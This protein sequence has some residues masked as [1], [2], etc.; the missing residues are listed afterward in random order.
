MINNSLERELRDRFEVINI[1][2]DFK[3]ARINVDEKY[4]IEN[5]LLKEFI[6]N[7]IETE[8]FGYIMKA[9]DKCIASVASKEEGKKT[10]KL[11][12]KHYMQENNLIKLQQSFIE[13]KITYI[14][15]KNN[16]KY[17]GTIKDNLERI[18][19]YNNEC[20]EPLI[21][22]KIIGISK[23]KKTISPKVYRTYSDKINI[24]EK[25]IISEGEEGY[26]LVNEQIVLSNNKIKHKEVLGEEVIKEPSKKIIV[27]G[28]K[29]PIIAG[30][31]FLQRPSIGRISSPYGMRNGKLH[32]GI[33][34]AA[35]MGTPIKA[36][37]D[38][39]VIYAGWQMGYGKVINIDH[40]NGITTVYAHCSLIKIKKGQKV[41]RGE[42]IGNVGSTGKS[43]GPHLHFEVRLNNIPQNP[44]DYLI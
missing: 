2:N 6:L 8:V 4:L 10:L 25:R 5:Y 43:T 21:T 1:Q 19:K 18:V 11:L 42:I 12:R 16:H 20:S 44:A 36:A 30:V 34:I 13:N 9:D 3:M 40:G 15:I 26:K 33:D 32:K 23:H 37:L 31:V 7:N 29:N 39:K 41:K 24:C 38:G 17:F 35:D 22:L 28:K 14:K 27:E